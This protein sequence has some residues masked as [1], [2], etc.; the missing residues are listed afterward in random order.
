[1]V[2]IKY[3][4]FIV[5]D[6]H[7]DSFLCPNGPYNEKPLRH[8]R[9]GA[10]PT[11]ITRGEGGSEK[12]PTIRPTEYR[13]YIK[14][15]FHQYATAGADT[16][17]RTKSFVCQ[18]TPHYGSTSRR[19][20]TLF[21]CIIHDMRTKVKTFFEISENFS[22]STIIGIV[23][24]QLIFCIFRLSSPVGIDFQWRLHYNGRE[25]G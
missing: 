8:S 25:I 17:S 12:Q 1:M 4:S 7:P 15:G 3:S 9:R 11:W 23:F 10:V 14:E 13:C 5:G 6:E 20:P 21:S 24:F 16:P 22:D 18:T 2:D 19:A